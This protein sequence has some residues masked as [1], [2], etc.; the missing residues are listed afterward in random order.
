MVTKW[1]PYKQYIDCALSS[2][3]LQA[4]AAFVAMRD[5]LLPKEPVLRAYK[6]R[7]IAE[8]DDLSLPEE[9]ADFVCEMVAT[10]G[11]EGLFTVQPAFY[12]L[13]G[14]GTLITGYLED[15]HDGLMRVKFIAEMMA[16]R[17]VGH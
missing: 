1:A 13:G 9:Y 8:M 3:D 6:D 11:A 15:L 5:G 14:V 7:A 12:E 2:D 4:G 16:A 17:P 10:M